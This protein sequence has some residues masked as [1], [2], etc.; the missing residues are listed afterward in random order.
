MCYHSL[1][2]KQ[3]S[4]ELHERKEEPKY[5]LQLI[6][7][8][9]DRE[10]RVRY[11]NP[12]ENKTLHKEIHERKLFDARKE[13]IKFEP[14]RQDICKS[15][16]VPYDDEHIY[17]LDAHRGLDKQ[18]PVEQRVLRCFYVMIDVVRKEAYYAEG[19]NIH[20]T[21]LDKI[22]RIAQNR[23]PEI[24]REKVFEEIKKD[25]DPEFLIFK[26]FMSL[27]NFSVLSKNNRKDQEQT[28]YDLEGNPI[29]TA[30][31][32]FISGHNLSQEQKT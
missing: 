9:N 14:I 20:V 11:I 15:F 17:I 10:K 13:K 4:I 23:H 2:K 22:I 16:G 29:E 27:D 19:R 32:W 25:K 31:G 30:E 12:E 18:K 7:I 3:F 24:I 28:I 26:G 6:A 21:L 5:R 1:M 8:I